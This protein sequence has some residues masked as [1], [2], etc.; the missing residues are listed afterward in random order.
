[1]RAAKPCLWEGCREPRAPGRG[2][3]LCEYHRKL[4]RRLRQRK[5]LAKQRALESQERRSEPAQARRVTA[6][7]RVDLAVKLMLGK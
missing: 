1:M 5:W 6:D 7:A 4:A 2:G 3:R